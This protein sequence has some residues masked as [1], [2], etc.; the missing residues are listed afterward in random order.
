MDRRAVIM[1][2]LLLIAFG[3][4]AWIQTKDESVRLGLGTAMC[5]L[6]FLIITQIRDLVQEREEEREVRAGRTRQRVR[7]TELGTP[8]VT[9]EDYLEFL[10]NNKAAREELARMCN[11]RVIELGL[12]AFGVE[13][14]NQHTCCCGQTH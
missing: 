9:R 1:I 13:K 11:A 4:F 7:V 5:G 12:D 3:I 8:Y 6:L 2:S 10:K 14:T